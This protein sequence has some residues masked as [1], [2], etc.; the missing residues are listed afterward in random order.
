MFKRIDA[1]ADGKITTDEVPEERREAVGRMIR[2]GDK[3]G[4]GA[5]SSDEFQAIAKL[6]A[7][8]AKKRP[9][10]SAKKTDTAKPNTAK[11]NAAK[12][13]EKSQGREEREEE[14]EGPSDAGQ[15]VSSG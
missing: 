4:D 7:E 11:P 14:Q 3:D 9:E 8:A 6:R 10:S 15:L 2:R 12:P 1:N 13:G 5:L